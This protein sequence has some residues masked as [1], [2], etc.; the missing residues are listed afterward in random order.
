MSYQS[1]GSH[2]FET[3]APEDGLELLDILEEEAFSGR[4]SLL[5]TRRPNAYT[6][7]L[8]EGEEVEIML[9]REE[10]NRLVSAFGVS[11]I[12]TLFLNG[13]PRR[14]GYLHS[15]RVRRRYQRRLWLQKGYAYMLREREKR[16]I[17]LFFTTILE[18]NETARRLLEKR[19]RTM[20]IY[21]LWDRYLGFAL[22][23]GGSSLTTPR[24][25]V[26]R[27][28]QVNQGD[29]RALVAFLNREGRRK[30]LFPVVRDLD[31]SNSTGSAP[32]LDD[33]YLLVD[34]EDQII[35]AGA[36]WDQRSFKQHLVAGYRGTFR[37]L[38]PLSFLFPVFGYP[39]LPRIGT[40]LNYATLSFWA[41]RDDDPLLFRQFL[42]GIRRAARRYDFLFL[43]MSEREHLIDVVQRVPHISYGSRLY[44]VYYEGD[45]AAR[46]TVDR[47]RIPYLEAGRL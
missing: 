3:A 47:R 16:K 19:R 11:S 20:P 22:K 39:R 18:E 15:L 33:F 42:S 30:Q 12:N 40:T 21:E 23:T 1:S 41:V 35:A 5:Y 43:G 36:L 29:L 7:F 28:R 44:I 34:N 31:F 2:F 25:G 45:E 4:I 24:R 17:A 26:Y 10:G 32:S 38:Y 6:S 13:E 14:V 37:L 8:R 27:F 9:I 46:N